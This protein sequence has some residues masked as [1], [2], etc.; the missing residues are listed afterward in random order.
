MAIPLKYIE[1]HMNRSG[2]VSNE[3]R[4]CKGLSEILSVVKMPLVAN[5]HPL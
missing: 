1:T 2:V 5:A 3:A 4:D